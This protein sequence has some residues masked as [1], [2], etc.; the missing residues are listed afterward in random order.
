MS[1]VCCLAVLC[2]LHAHALGSPRSDPTV[3]RA[4][5]T[6]ATLPNATSIDLDPAALGLGISDEL[7]VATMATLDTYSIDRKHLDLDTGALSSGEHVDSTLLSPGVMA[8]F[9]WHPGSE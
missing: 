3:G 2:A 7:Y 5:F 9:I 6:G 4:V 8:A 1:R